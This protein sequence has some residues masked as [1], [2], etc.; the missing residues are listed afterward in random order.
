MGK[1]SLN[2]RDYSIDAI[3]VMRYSNIVEAQAITRYLIR[4]RPQN[5]GLQWVSFQGFLGSLHLER[6]FLWSYRRT[7]VVMVDNVER[8]VV[9]PFKMASSCH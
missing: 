5:T 6:H 4:N 1:Q 3:G 7:L 8:S 2:N 9:S